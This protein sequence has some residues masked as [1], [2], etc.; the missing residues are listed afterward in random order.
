[1]ASRIPPANNPQHHPHVNPHVNFPQNAVGPFVW[2]G[3]MLMDG[4]GNT[5]GRIENLAPKVQN[6]LQD[7]TETKTAEC[8]SRTFC[9][10]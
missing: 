9:E 3:G 1:M 8:A 5:W 10:Q 7:D 6:P 2:L 4:A